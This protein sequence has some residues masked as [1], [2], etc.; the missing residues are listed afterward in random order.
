MLPRACK[1]LPGERLRVAFDLPR[2]ALRD[3]FAAQPSRAGTE[4]D[5]VIGALDGFGVV[6]DHQ[7]GVAQVAQ[8]RQRIEQPVVVARMQADG[9]FIEHV[10]HTAQLRADLRGQ[11]N[12]LRFAAGKRRRR[13][14]Q[15][16]IIEADGDQKFQAV[17]DF[18]DRAPADLLF[19]IVELPALHGLERAR[20]GTS[21]SDPRSS[22]P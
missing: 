16:Q 8:T 11:T 21:R 14:L 17:A 6:L 2:R 3:Q 18:V 15:A 5:H 10:Q 19:A 20:S 22:G 1:I 13:T 12:A 9:R 4:I 7:H